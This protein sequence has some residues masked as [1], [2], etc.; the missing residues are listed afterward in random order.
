MNAKQRAQY[1]AGAEIMKALAHPARLLIVDMLA[2]KG[3]CCV[4]DLTKVI[5]SD[6]STVSR[7]LAELKNVGIV[8]S[9]KRGQMVYYRLHVKCIVRVFE[10]IKSV[11]KSN[12]NRHAKLLAYDRS[13][14]SGCG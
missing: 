14:N 12:A 4:C 10:C 13:S 9:E 5:G 8:R 7:H 6:T 11:A 1:E 2:D 3:E